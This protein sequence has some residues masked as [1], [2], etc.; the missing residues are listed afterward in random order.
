MDPKLFT[1]NDTVLRD[2]DILGEENTNY[3]LRLR[4]TESY[5]IIE[6]IVTE[7][8]LATI[9]K[10]T[11]KVLENNTYAAVLAGYPIEKYSLEYIK[12]IGA[13]IVIPVVA[14][15]AEADFIRINK[16][17]VQKFRKVDKVDVFP[18]ELFPDGKEYFYAKTVV[19]RPYVEENVELPTSFELGMQWQSSRVRIRRT[20]KSIQ[21]IDVSSIKARDVE[22]KE[23]KILLEIPVEWKDYQILSINNEETLA[24]IEIIKF[25]PDEAR[26]W[27]QR[28]WVHMKFNRADNKL[29]DSNNLILK[30]LELAENYFG[31]EVFESKKLY[32]TS[33][34][35]ILPRVTFK[36][37][38]KGATKNE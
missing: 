3:P 32:K 4:L 2:L 29:E 13:P 11:A 22:G 38:L 37:S 15:L 10:T 19:D 7:S 24:E 30:R 35:S 5:L 12:S 23:W 9:E 27:D 8:Q 28:K 20:E 33:T 31:F 16:S 36:Y 1:F 26:P 25:Y 34:G 6:K 14:K 18:V 21:F 17:S